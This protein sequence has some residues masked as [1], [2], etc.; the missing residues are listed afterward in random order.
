MKNTQIYPIVTI[1]PPTI[2][3]NWYDTITDS[4]KLSTNNVSLH[5]IHKGYYENYDAGT[6]P[7]ISSALYSF[8]PILLNI[9][10]IKQSVDIESRKFKINNVS[11]D[12]S[13]YK[14]NGER[15][16]DI[17]LDTSLINWKVSIQFVS[18]T[19]DRFY[20]IGLTSGIAYPT[21]TSEEK[22]VPNSFYDIYT[23]TGD[24]LKDY[25]YNQDI[26]SHATDM[27]YQG[28]IRR[29][30]HDDE[31]V[32]VE[33]ED[34]TEQKAN[35][36]LPKNYINTESLPDKHKNKPKPIVYGEVDRSPL[37]F[38][39][40]DNQTTL[41]ADEDNTVSYKSDEPLFIRES[42]KYII[43]PEEAVSPRD[44]EV[45]F[46]SGEDPSADK[47]YDNSKQY[48]V[49]ENLVE[50][51][52]DANTYT[53]TPDNDADDNADDNPTGNHVGDNNLIVMQRE[54]PT[55]IT[56]KR[57]FEGN[58]RYYSVKHD[59]STVTF[60]EPSGDW[61]IGEEVNHSNLP[62][63]IR[64]IIFREILNDDSLALW[65]GHPP[66]NIVD[67][68]IEGAAYFDDDSGDSG[69]LGAEFKMPIATGFGARSRGYLYAKLSCGLFNA[70]IQGTSFRVRLGGSKKGDHFGGSEGTD[71]GTSDDAGY[72]KF[73]SQSAEGEFNLDHNYQPNSNNPSLGGFNGLPNGTG[74][75]ITLNSIDGD[76]K[77]MPIEK[78]DSL[79]F[80]IKI[81]HG[82]GLCAGQGRF[83]DLYVEHFELVKDLNKQEYYGDLKGRKNTLSHPYLAQDELIENPID[84]IYD[85]LRNEIGLDE[86]QINEH[87][88]NEA[89]NA[90]HDWKFAFTV[91]KKIDSKK[92][93]EEIAKSTKC[94]PKLKND[95]TFGFNTI[96]DSYTPT[97]ID[98][99]IL[100]KEQEV[101]NYSFKKTKPEQIVSEVGVRYKKD[102]AQ[103]SYSKDVFTY[104][105]S[106]YDYNKYD[107][108]TDYPDSWEYYGIGNA[109]DAFLEVE[110][111]YIRDDFTAHKLREFLFN[112]HKNDHLIFNV[113][114][115][116]SYNQLEVG[117]LV[118]FDKLFGGIKAY[119]ID[120]TQT[121]PINGQTRYPIFMI[122]SSKKNLDSIEI[123]C[124]Q[125]H[126]LDTNIEIDFYNENWQETVDDDTDTDW[127]ALD[128][129][130]DVNGDGAVNILDVVAMVAVIQG[131]D[132]W[133]N[134][135]VQAPL[136]DINDDGELNIL[137]VVG[138][139]LLI[140]ART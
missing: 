43:V 93:I 24:S 138:T 127:Y 85:I 9:P 131:N 42:D 46:Q 117:D 87:E 136:A 60:F 84:I 7:V 1:E 89:R 111:D 82:S 16:S 17:L 14:Y 36:D 103:D 101:I 30:S 139:V 31:K 70:D 121:I 86:S 58:H 65:Q 79:L 96:K 52:H 47:V 6:Q 34:L 20:T 97:E 72:I 29:I 49:F 90:H 39:I 114:L 94:F 45:L 50:F 69:K 78:S 123:E 2:A 12:I 4:I 8:K 61:D 122:T 106:T 77:P 80:Y 133:G 91:N 44:N 22:K 11:L 18:P 5:H 129:E 23:D 88:Y 105:E 26:R 55:L 74:T 25:V 135:E 63:T 92:L 124:M 67:D 48:S 107:T 104:T 116:I 33:L 10:S 62:I 98:N 21:D 83:E 37:V 56:A 66:S 54:R 134:P 112:Y 130:G 73:S 57:T 68:A 100:I 64:G 76:N 128:E 32:K 13:N 132:Y 120:Y 71:A 75:G 115:P 137:D 113:K 41:I 99:A 95:G 51:N 110:S 53:G 108:F 40:I 102:Y 81:S 109:E 119:G 140:M 15:F 3:V 126:N 19:S 38:D 118:K 35:K 59:D 28:V 27:V 125:L